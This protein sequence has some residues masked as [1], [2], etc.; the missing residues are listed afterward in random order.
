MPARRGH[1]DGAQQVLYVPGRSRD[2]KTGLSKC[3]TFPAGADA[4]PDQGN[5]RTDKR[6][7]GPWRDGGQGASKAPRSHCAPATRLR[8]LKSS[9]TGTATPAPMAGDP[10]LSP[11]L[12]LD[13][14]TNNGSGPP[15]RLASARMDPVPTDAA[16]L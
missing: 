4:R 15:A 16:T 12:P 3:F 14:S 6:E 9:N 13:A 2:T 8:Q 5:E 1:E 7:D 10:V 11:R